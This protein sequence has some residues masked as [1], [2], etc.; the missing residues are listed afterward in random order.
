MHSSFLPCPK[1]FRLAQQ[2]NTDH[3]ADSRFSG[4][5][6]MFWQFTSLNCSLI[7]Q[8]LSW[9]APYFGL[10]FIKWCYSVIHKVM[11][12]NRLAQLATRVKYRS[13]TEF[14]KSQAKSLH[15]FVGLAMRWK[16][17]EVVWVTVHDIQIKW[18][19][20]KV[21][22]RN[23]CKPVTQP[24]LRLEYQFLSRPYEPMRIQYYNASSYH[25]I[26]HI[27]NKLTPGQP[28]RSGLGGN[29]MTACESDSLFTVYFTLP[30]K[31]IG[32]HKWK[33]TN[34]EGRSQKN[35][36]LTVGKASKA[37]TWPAA[38]FKERTFNSSGFSAEGALVSCIGGVPRGTNQL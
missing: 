21:G 16:K 13:E 22:T 34:P 38:D 12:L 11:Y 5:S 36:F 26:W 29:T 4:E 23:K 19:N 10:K 3:Y 17:E 2:P 24:G 1:A 25:M 33:W 32:G 20:W 18:N 14:M 31:R 37:I 9:V 27:F 30:W 35:R 15:V 8:I 28:W 6:R 7:A